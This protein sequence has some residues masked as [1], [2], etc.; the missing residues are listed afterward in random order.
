VGSRVPDILC[1]SGS[2]RLVKACNDS[3]MGMTDIGPNLL[4]R[5]VRYLWDMPNG[6]RSP[7]RCQGAAPDVVGAPVAGAQHFHRDRNS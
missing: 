1:I 6:R 7:N 3:E 4:I 5:D 2:R